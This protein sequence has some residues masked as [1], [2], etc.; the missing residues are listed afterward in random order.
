[1]EC[2]SQQMGAQNRIRYNPLS[3]PRYICQGDL[4]FTPRCLIF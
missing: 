1:L 2:S 4:D 3:Q